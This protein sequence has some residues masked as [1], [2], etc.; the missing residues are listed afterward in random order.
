MQF[1]PNESTAFAIVTKS[2]TGDG[3]PKVCKIVGSL[4]TCDEEA[5]SDCKQL[6]KDFD[7]TGKSEPYQAV[8]IKVSFLSTLQD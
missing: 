6:N 1:L 5:K 4:Y 3:T 8:E 7:S 2:C